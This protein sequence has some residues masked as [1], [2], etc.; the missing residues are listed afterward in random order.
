MTVRGATAR[1]C[2]VPLFKRVENK[3]F[4]T[5]CLC[6]KDLT[7]FSTKLNG[8]LYRRCNQCRDR[9]AKYNEGGRKNKEKKRKE[10]GRKPET[11]YGTS[12]LSK[13]YSPR[14][15][16]IYRKLVTLQWTTNTL[17]I[18]HTGEQL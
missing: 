17:N 3:E 8:S 4:C 14:F 16:D 11:Y 13:V 2:V 18:E 9:D 5:G 10:T 12:F 1:R 6:Y 15:Y 7:E